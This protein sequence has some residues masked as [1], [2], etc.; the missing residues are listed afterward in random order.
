PGGIH[1]V[2]STDNHPSSGT[3]VES[4]SSPR[5]SAQ[6]HADRSSSTHH[7]EL[8]E[9]LDAGILEDLAIFVKPVTSVERASRAVRARDPEL[10]GFV[11]EHGREERVTDTLALLRSEQIDREQVELSRGFDAL[12]RVRVFR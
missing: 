8:H 9:T 4:A 6:P 2:W 1:G 11:A 5:R 7:A 3:R 10:G 12:Q